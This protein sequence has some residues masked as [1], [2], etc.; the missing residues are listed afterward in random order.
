MN[1]A[2]CNNKISRKTNTIGTGYGINMQDEKICYPCCGEEDKEYMRKHGRIMLYFSVF[3]NGTS[4]FG[5]VTN[6]PGS[7]VFNYLEYTKGG[8]NWGLDRYDVWFPFDGY[9]WH[10]VNIGNMTELCHCK[11]TK[12]KA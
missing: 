9:I 4:N 7:L 12:Q 10:G 1:C 6:W 5:K 2:R 8:H 3:N 11:R